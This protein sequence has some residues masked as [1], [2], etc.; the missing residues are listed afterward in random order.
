MTISRPI[1]AYLDPV[2]RSWAYDSIGLNTIR[3]ANE[4]V[5]D[6]ILPS[7]SLYIYLHKARLKKDSSTRDDLELIAHPQWDIYLPRTSHSRLQL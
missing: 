4:I 2:S 3:F 5:D 6:K 7:S 1:L